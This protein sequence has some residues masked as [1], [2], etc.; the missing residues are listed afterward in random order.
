[1]NCNSSANAIDAMAGFSILRQWPTRSL[2]NTVND[3]GN[4]YLVSWSRIECDT[5]PI[6]VQPNMES[7]AIGS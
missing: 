3:V 7:K 1:M 2:I 6:N 4:E 5:E